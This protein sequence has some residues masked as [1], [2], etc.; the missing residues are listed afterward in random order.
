VA[1][2]N[3]EKMAV[4]DPTEDMVYAALYQGISHVEPLMKKLARKQPPTLQ[5]LRNKVEE[6]IHHEEMLKAMT[7]S[8][9]SWDRSPE[10]KMR[11]FRKS[12]KKDQRWEKISQI[13]T[14]RLWMQRYQKSSW[15]SREIQRFASHR[16]YQATLHI[17]MRASIA[18]SMSREA[19]TLRGA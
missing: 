10:R 12:D 6:Y 15:K 9:P 16:R 19:I 7:S 11:E 4:E 1:R 13:T 2:F 3:Q 18:I 8:R 14:L 17:R 5:G